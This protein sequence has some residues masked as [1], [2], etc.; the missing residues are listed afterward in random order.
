V[1]S[2]FE[3]N[4]DG[5]YTWTLTVHHFAGNFDASLD[6]AGLVI[7]DAAG[8][9]SN[10]EFADTS[11][12]D[13]DYFG[14]LEDQ[15]SG[16]DAAAFFSDCG[17]ELECVVDECAPGDDETLLYSVDG[18]SAERDSV[19][20]TLTL[21]FAFEGTTAD[22]ALSYALVL[23]GVDLDAEGTDGD[24]VWEA[25]DDAFGGFVAFDTVVDNEDGTFS[26]TMTFTD[27][28]A[29]FDDTYAADEANFADLV[30]MGAELYDVS[31]NAYLESDVTEAE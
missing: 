6:F 2:R 27:M 11:G 12:E 28:A 7:Y 25:G 24:G 29:F 18:L 23:F 20:D 9:P 26:A 8:N 21:T 13:I 16:C 10:L 3:D 17:Y 22:V 4:L 19:G 5:T 1:D 30:L 15:A 31:A 14:P